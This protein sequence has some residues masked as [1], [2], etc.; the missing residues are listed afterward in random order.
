M[1]VL[2]DTNVFI[3]RED[4]Q[5]V[6]NELQQLLN[7]LN[8][9]ECTILVHPLSLKEVQKNPRSRQRTVLES[10]IRTYPFLEDPPDPLR[11]GSVIG[12]LGEARI[13]SNY[14]D[15]SLIE[16]VKKNA[17]DRLITEDKGI[18]RLA[19]RFGIGDRVSHIDE[20]LVTFQEF[21]PK[22][23]TRSPPSLRDVPLHN[24]NLEDHI[25]DQ[26]RNE[27]TE[28]DDWFQ[29]ASR[30][31]RRAWVHFL[32]DDSIGA[33]LIY[34]IEDE[35]IDCEPPLP[36]RKRLK[37]CTI[38]VSRTGYRIGE[39]LIKTSMEFCMKNDIWEIYLT[40]FIENDDYLVSLIEEFG[41]LDYAATSRGERL[42]LKRIS[43]VGEEVE[44]YE[45][46]DLS[47]RFY[48]SYYDGDRVNKFIIPIRP[49]F[50]EILFTDYRKRQT[51]LNEHSG[52]FIVEGNTIKKAYLCKSRIKRL[53]S[54]DVIIFYRSGDL[55]AITSIGVVDEIHSQM[56]SVDEIFN[57]IHK[58]TVYNINEIKRLVSSSPVLVILFR[59][60][61]HLNVSM[62]LREMIA[63]GVLS[64]PPQSIIQITDGQYEI[65]KGDGRIDERF[66]IN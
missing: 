45:P 65:I 1:R 25:F 56:S 59:Q 55:K 3:Y 47:R 32:D 20:A 22:Y 30:R 16:A 9:I 17:V 54:G 11:D 40:H 28:F 24:I 23:A 2:I 29:K 33:I 38:K 15:I 61:L 37:I 10:K 52:G 64:A 43:T 14:V 41:F 66:T 6:S 18:H 34:K 63:N 50:H 48:P 8:S 26:L 4:E 51:R 44:G 27:Y 19:E 49:Q 35:A 58:R 39:L 21:V 53:N 62:S 42:F 13:K 5:V 57:L 60:H 46:S 7:I 36:K 31:G 12:L